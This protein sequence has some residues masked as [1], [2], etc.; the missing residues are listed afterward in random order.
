VYLNKARERKIEERGAEKKEK[1]EKSLRSHSLSTLDF[2]F[3]SRVHR[4]IL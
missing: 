4:S 2:L 3:R 1:E